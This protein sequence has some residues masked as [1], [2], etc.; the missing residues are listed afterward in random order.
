MVHGDRRGHVDLIE[1]GPLLAIDLDTDKPPIHE[2][3]NRLVLEGFPFHDMTPMA[4][5]IA[6]RE[7]DRTILF[8]GGLQG[9]RSPG[10]PLHGVVGML[11]QVGTRFMNES[12]GRSYLDANDMGVNLASRQEQRQR[13]WAGC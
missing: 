6:D 7:Q 8:F 13:R 4:G 3:R 2:R 1:I 10:V 5:G 9:F 11:Q 12:I